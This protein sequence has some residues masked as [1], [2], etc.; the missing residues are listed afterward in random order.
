MLITVSPSTYHIFQNKTTQ[1][2]IIQ[3]ETLFI[4][5]FH[6]NASKFVAACQLMPTFTLPYQ[7]A[8]GYK[9]LFPVFFHRLGL[10]ITSR[11]KKGSKS[12][13]SSGNGR[14]FPC[15]FIFIDLNISDFL[16]AFISIAFQK[17]L[18]TTPNCVILDA[19]FT[20]FFCSYLNENTNFI[21]M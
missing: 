7:H 17:E 14:C 1:A 21:E 2:L 12:L 4:Q 3:K 19:S 20:H 11:L 9:T 18:W 15:G 16:Q 8:I 6:S 10:C 13:S 5:L